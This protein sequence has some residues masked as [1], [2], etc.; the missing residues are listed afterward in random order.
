MYF[1]G[2]KRDRSRKRLAWAPSYVIYREP[3][4]FWREPVAEKSL[5][6]VIVFQPAYLSWCSSSSAGDVLVQLSSLAVLTAQLG[7]T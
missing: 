4:W 2:L 5:L 7:G 6:E 1:H 3:E